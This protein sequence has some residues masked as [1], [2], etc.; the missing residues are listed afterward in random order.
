DHGDHYL[1]LADYA[2]YMAA[3]ARVDALYA[4]ADAWTTMA[5]RNVAGMG[6][7]SSDRTVL[8]Y[9]AKVWDVRS[10]NT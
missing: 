6:P 10:L 1:L 4:D 2:Q 9:A 5:I 8:E 7:F 3:H